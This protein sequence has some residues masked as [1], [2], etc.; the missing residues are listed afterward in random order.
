MELR[1]RGRTTARRLLEAGLAEFGERGFNAVTVDDI[2]R[3]ANT[4]PETYYL[5]FTS[6]ND[7]LAALSHP[8]LRAFD[9]LIDQFPVVTHDD[10]GRAALRGW[11]TAFCDTY[12]AHAAVI[13]ILNHAG[14]IGCGTFQDD[15]HW[16]PS[17]L[18][19]V[20]CTGMMATA[21]KTEEGAT[22]AMV[23]GRLAAVACLMMLE[24][25]SYLLTVGVRLSEGPTIDRLTG[26]ILAGFQTLEHPQ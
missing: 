11:V 3:R 13:K 10:A 17:R 22:D 15:L 25:V 21:A 4:S 2:A 26:I 19:D 23:G 16:R 5:Y 8:A 14:L 24:R 1:D 7:L 9:A 6:K 18:A 12:Q 20:L